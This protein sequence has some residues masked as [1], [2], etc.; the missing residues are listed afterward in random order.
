MAVIKP[1]QCLGWEGREKVRRDWV[2]DRAVLIWR[3]A[4]T[5]L[6]LLLPRFAAQLGNAL[7]PLDV[8]SSL[9]PSRRRS[10]RRVKNRTSLL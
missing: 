4:V 7:M 3:A 2:N 1:G 10:D 8:Y 6:E 5:R 9:Q